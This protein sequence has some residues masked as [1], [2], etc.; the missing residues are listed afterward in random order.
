MAKEY[1]KV[2]IACTAAGQ[3]P[4]SITWSKAVGSLLKD[5]TEVKYG[6]L[7]IHRVTKNDNGI[8]IFTADNILGSVTGKAHLMMLTLVIFRVWSRV[9]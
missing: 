2:T 4:A 5:R 9:I 8:Y 1:Q 3:P 6:T 7:I